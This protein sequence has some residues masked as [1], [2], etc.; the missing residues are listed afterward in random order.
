MGS[1]LC[2]LKK[3]SEDS[4]EG[5]YHTED[6][7]DWDS[8]STFSLD[9]TEVRMYEEALKKSKNSGNYF[10]RKPFVRNGTAGLFT[11]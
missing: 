9:S 5:S 8:D 11:F 4:C 7:D 2:V 1:A 10:R 6:N 3:S